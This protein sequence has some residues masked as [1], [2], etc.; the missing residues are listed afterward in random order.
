MAQEIRK[1]VENRGKIWEVKGKLEWK[2]Q[3]L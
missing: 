1:N 2:V 3:T